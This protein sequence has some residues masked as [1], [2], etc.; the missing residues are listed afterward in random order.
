[1]MQQPTL[2]HQKTRA[3]QPHKLSAPRDFIVPTIINEIEDNIPL[4]L[5]IG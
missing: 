5:E 4:L 3:F 1:M 2:S